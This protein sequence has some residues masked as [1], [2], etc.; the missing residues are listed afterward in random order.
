MAADGRVVYPLTTT[1]TLP[2]T[3]APGSWVD[4]E[5]SVT[6]LE[7]S[8]LMFEVEDKGDSYNPQGLFVALWDGDVPSDRAAEQ[9]AAPRSYP[10]ASSSS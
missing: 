2:A 5:L 1:G 4:F 8:N 6:G 3:C 9:C 10:G 7:N